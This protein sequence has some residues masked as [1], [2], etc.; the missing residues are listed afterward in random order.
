M[1]GDGCGGQ[2]GYGAV[3]IAMEEAST[4]ETP[5]SLSLPLSE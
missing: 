1:S 5:L 3:A 2:G 4:G